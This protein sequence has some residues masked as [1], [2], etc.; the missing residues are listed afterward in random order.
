M[1]ASAVEKQ[2]AEAIARGEKPPE[3]AQGI[4]IFRRPREGADVSDNAGE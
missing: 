3:R 1:A 4:G 2:V